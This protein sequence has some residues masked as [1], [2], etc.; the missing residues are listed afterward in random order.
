MDL[1]QGNRESTEEQETLIRNY[2]ISCI[3]T[4]NAERAD[5][6]L[7]KIMEDEDLITN[8]LEFAQKDHKL[9]PCSLWQYILID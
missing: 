3:G 7:K 8:F 5:Y 4:E 6:Y 2:L 1:E 9:D